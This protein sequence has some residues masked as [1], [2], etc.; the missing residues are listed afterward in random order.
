MTD[1]ELIGLLTDTTTT[2]PDVFINLNNWKQ[3]YRDYSKMIHTD[4]CSHPKA[5]DAVSK[6]NNM[7]D[8]IT[9]GEVHKD[10]AGDVRFYQGG[11]VEITAEA[12]ILKHSF[13]NW[14]W[15]RVRLV[16]KFVNVFQC[17]VKS[18]MELSPS[19]CRVELYHFLI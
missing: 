5:G 17:E 18:K 6:L 1:V 8:T 15:L 3:I 10:D 14:T 4:R 7:R 19:N 16:M 12:N 9:K 13:N 11:T 2:V